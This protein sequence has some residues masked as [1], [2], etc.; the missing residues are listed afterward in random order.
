M[1]LHVFGGLTPQ[2]GDSQ[3]ASPLLQLVF[4]GSVHA[5]AVRRDLSHL[6]PPG[7]QYLSELFTFYV[8]SS[9]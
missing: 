7:C 4:H 8:S 3:R 2:G 1:A 9:M 5:V 6:Q